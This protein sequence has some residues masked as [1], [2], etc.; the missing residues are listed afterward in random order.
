MSTSVDSRLA[1]LTASRGLSFAAAT[2]LSR[3]ARQPTSQDLETFHE[4]ETLNRSISA[5]RL[6]LSSSVSRSLSPSSSVSRSLSP[7][8]SSYAS[9]SHSPSS[10]LA[11]PAADNRVRALEAQVRKL[12]IQLAEE[13]MR[14]ATV[15]EE[16][17]N[18]RGELSKSN[19]VLITFAQRAR[20]DRERVLS[21][22]S[23]LNGRKRLARS[24]PALSEQTG[25]IEGVLK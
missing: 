8:S 19:D 11:S 3:N 14:N 6:G 24:E 2:A 23:E 5:P 18:V 9:D 25:E 17:H 1:A 10:G 13:Q 16:L 21:E 4:M 22:E 20:Q 15:V 12:K 7:S